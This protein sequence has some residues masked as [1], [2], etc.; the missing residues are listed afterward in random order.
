MTTSSNVHI[1]PDEINWLD[2]L[3]VVAEN[4]RLLLIGP[5]AAGLVALGVTFFFRPTFTATTVFLPPQQ[6]QSAA[7][8]L[9]QSLG[10]LGGITNA[11]TGLKN[12]NDQFVAF[13]R[14]RYVE[15]NLIE[16]FQL[17][18]RFEVK[19]MAEARK[20]LE[21]TVDIR[22]NKDGLIIV[23]VDD[24]DPIFAAK[25]A[26]AHVEE[27]DKLMQ[28]MA[29]TEAQQRRAFFEIQLVSTKD[30]LTKAEMALRSSGVNS[31]ALKSDPKIAVEVV[32][33][34]QAE[35][36][37]QEVKIASMRS[38]LSESAPVFKLAVS[39]L[40][41]LR[42]QLGKLEKTTDTSNT[43]DSD[44]V[45]R[46]RDFKYYETLFEL[47]AKQF[48]LAKVDESRESGVVQVLDRALPPEIKS[49]PKRGLITIVTTL[50]TGVLLLVFVFVRNSYRKLVASQDGAKRIAAIGTAIRKRK[51]G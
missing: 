14:S 44:Y 10:A 40:A 43:S 42:A 33:R 37:A 32:A 35:V 45:A 1:D 51:N 18:D 8:L 46:F 20:A 19:M 11:A 38:Y 23:D 27:L 6:Q 5:I 22:S 15:D 29:V 39:E 26:N 13:L 24:H 31:S 34:V 41:G 28:R 7:S 9:L 16:Q 17:K 30:K 12:P 49:K 4:I 48:E 36:A 21:Q 47:F 3:Q 50:A 25:L 2:L